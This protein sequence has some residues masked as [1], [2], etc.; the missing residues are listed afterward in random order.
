[1]TFRRRF[2]EIRI[3]D[4]AATLA[5]AAAPVARAEGFELHAQS[6]EARISDNGT[7]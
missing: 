6:M 7:Q 3:G 1:M 2:S 5:R 4:G